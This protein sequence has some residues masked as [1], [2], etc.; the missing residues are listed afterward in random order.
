MFAPEERVD[1]SVCAL[2]ATPSEPALPRM[3][4]QAA[5]NAPT[6]T[7]TSMTD[8]WLS[9]NNNHLLK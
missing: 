2:H 6:Q 9:L 3:S 5:Q 8:P 4:Q 1:N 7:Q